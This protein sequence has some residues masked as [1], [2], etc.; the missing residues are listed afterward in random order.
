MSHHFWMSQSLADWNIDT[1]TLLAHLQLAFISVL[2][3]SSPAC[4]TVYKRIFTLFARSSQI[5][6][7]P[8]EYISSSR[9]ADLRAT[10]INLVLTLTAQVQALPD[11]VFDTEL[12]ELDVWFNE[13]FEYLRRN[14]GSAIGVE[15]SLWV[16]SNEQELLNTWEAMRVVARQ[17][18]GWQIGA[19]SGLGSTDRDL[20]EEEEDEEGEYAPVI[21]EIREHR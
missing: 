7:R 1:N 18:F 11:S 2:H 13:E 14:L 15:G 10:Y 6:L 9:H 4:L 5:H 17:K 8:S 21:V 19:L 12:P 3:L 20:Y 16:K